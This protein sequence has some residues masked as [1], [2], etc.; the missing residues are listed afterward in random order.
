M[1]CNADCGLFA[2]NGRSRGTLVDILFLVAL[3]KPATVV[4][5]GCLGAITIGSFDDIRSM[6]GKRNPQHVCARG[7]IPPQEQACCLDLFMPSVSMASCL[8][9]FPMTKADA[10]SMI[11]GSPASLDRKLV[12][13]TESS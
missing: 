7:F 5:L 3:G 2:W 13:L 9:S 8:S 1:A 11:L 12:L 6:L 4:R 10:I